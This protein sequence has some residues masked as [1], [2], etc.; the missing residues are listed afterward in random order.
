MNSSDGKILRMFRAEDAVETNQAEA[1]EIDI[2][3]ELAQS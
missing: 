2:P 3:A 1:R